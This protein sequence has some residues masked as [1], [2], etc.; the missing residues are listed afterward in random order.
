MCSHAPY[1]LLDIPF[2]MEPVKV[3]VLACQRNAFLRKLITR[4]VKCEAHVAV[5]EKA[6]KGKGESAAAAP[7][8]QLFKVV[9]EDSVLFPEGGGQPADR[10][11]LNVRKGDN[12]IDQ[13]RVADVQRAGDVCVIYAEG[14]VEV[15]SEVE[16]E[17]DWPRRLDHI[18]HHSGQHLLTAVVEAELG[19]PTVAWSLSHPTCYLQLGAPAGHPPGPLTMIPSDQLCRIEDIVN[20]HIR[21]SG[22]VKCHVFPNRDSLPPSRSR[23]IPEDVTGPIRIIEINAGA[24]TDPASPTVDSCT[25]CGTH[26]S[27][28]H[29][30][31]AVKLLHQDLVKGGEVLRLHFVFGNRVLK[32]FGEM[33]QRERAIA[34]DLGGA[35]PDEI[36]G[37]VAKRGIDLTDSQKVSKKLLAELTTLQAPMVGAAAAEYAATNPNGVY[38]FHSDDFGDMAYLMTLAS[39]AKVHCTSLLSFR[40][41][42]ESQYLIAGPDAAKV[43]R[44]GR[45]LVKHAEGKGGG[46]GDIRGKGPAKK[47][48]QFTGKQLTDIW[49]SSEEEM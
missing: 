47:L 8:G 16:A 10:G 23:K 40:Q 19:M 29:Q 17:V 37:R 13:I 46:K 36:V 25:C 35:L 9:L 20:G 30:L 34:Q 22:E 31:Q 4:V 15:G 12:T 39:A 2:V 6:K 7:G 45:L 28:L 3:G 41:G 5:P 43:Q 11:W 48:K 32:Q 44:L 14:P 1:L 38:V 18:Q 26:V 27:S 21:N 24:D 33:Y 49:A 42:D